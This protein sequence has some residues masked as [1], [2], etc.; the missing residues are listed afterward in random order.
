MTILDKKG[1]KYEANWDDIKLKINCKNQLYSTDIKATYQYNTAVCYIVSF[2]PW[3][4]CN[5]L[6]FLDICLYLKYLF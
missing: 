2:K 1:I 3:R 4:C 5:D 6:T